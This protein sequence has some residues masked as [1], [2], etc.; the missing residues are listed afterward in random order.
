[1]KNG[2]CAE[3][4]TGRHRYV[5]LIALLRF[6]S[7]DSIGNLISNTIAIECLELRFGE[8]AL[9]AAQ[10]PAGLRQILIFRA[11]IVYLIFYILSCMDF[12]RKREMIKLT[13]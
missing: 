5:R 8:I 10:T 9:I 11:S 7:T 13:K 1:M 2:L 3:K 12:M 4:H 6:F